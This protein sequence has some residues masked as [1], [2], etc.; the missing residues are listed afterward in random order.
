[1]VR[2]VL[3]YAK[4][5][6]PE[7]KRR[8]EEVAAWLKKQQVRVVDV[9]RT[10]GVLDARTLAGVVLA[11]VF[12]G[13]GT[14]LRLVRRLE[15]KD[16]F[17][18][19]GINLGTVG[20]IT[21]VAPEHAV[22]AVADALAGKYPESPR[23]LLQVELFRGKKCAAMG[24]VFNDAVLAKDAR[25]SMLMF[26]VI[27][28]D[29]TLSRVRADGY[30][31]ATAT[32]STAYSLSASGPLMFPDVPANVLVPICPHAL[33]SRPMVVSDSVPIEIR[34][35][36]FDGSVYLVFDGQISHEIRTGDRIRITRSPAALRLVRSPALSWV[37]ALRTK[38]DMA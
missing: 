30:I 27:V 14:F 34:P 4:R 35:T 20:F 21:D 22:A 19:L 23:P 24:F 8:L 25:T 2:K 29:E 6:A 5:D 26:D 31:V 38:L 18:V 16:K 7:A 10:E 28:G 36:Q 37:R 13:D 12:G 9:T 1:M 17:P 15:R 3:L 11:V 32:G 33:S